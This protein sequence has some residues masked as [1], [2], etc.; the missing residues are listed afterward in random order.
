MALSRPITINPTV[1]V[2][3]GIVT[4][5]ERTNNLCSGY[6]SRPVAS[7]R[8]LST[9]PRSTCGTCR[10]HSN[11]SLLDDLHKLARRPQRRRRPTCHAIHCREYEPRTKG[12]RIPLQSSSA[13]VSA[14]RPGLGRCRELRVVVYSVRTR[15]CSRC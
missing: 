7:A 8:Y 9:H 10:L 14:L 1:S 3:A 5:V 15:C 2:V 12:M 13:S 4:G 6:I 11:T